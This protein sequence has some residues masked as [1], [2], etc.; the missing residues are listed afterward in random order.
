MQKKII[1]SVVLLIIVAIGAGFWWYQ[2]QARIQAEITHVTIGAL[3]PITG[4]L[5]LIGQQMRNGMEMAR[6]DLVAAGT[7]KSLNIIYEDAC[8]EATSWVAAR[9]LVDVD[10]VKMIASSFCIYGY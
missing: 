8:N 4:H 10:R 2:R 6:E 5:S 1:L 9:K 3:V 7:V